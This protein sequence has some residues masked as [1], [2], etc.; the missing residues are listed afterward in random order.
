MAERYSY[1]RK[2]NYE[3]SMRAVKK[4]FEAAVAAGYDLI[5]V[6]PTIDITLPRDRSSISTQLL[7]GPLSLL[8]TPKIFGEI[9]I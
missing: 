7:P 2:W 9:W 5:H 8:F 1:T 3:D 6:D 4:S